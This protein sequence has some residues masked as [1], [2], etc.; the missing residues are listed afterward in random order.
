VAF[1]NLVAEN[2]AAA[3]P[4]GEEAA[5][6]R[7]LGA[8]EKLG[9]P[10]AVYSVVDVGTQ[11]RPERVDTTVVLEAKPPGISEAR[12]RLTAVF[13]G[14]KLAYF[15]P[16]IHV[17][18]SFLRE[19]RRRTA[20]D[21]L[22]LGARVVASGALVGIAIIL[23]LR[24]VRRPG[25]RW[26][27]I[28]TPLVAAG[29]LAAASLANTA[30]AA[31]R[32]YE[33]EKPF[34]L[35][36][37]GLGISLTVG[38]AVILLGALVGFVL[39]SAARPGWPAALRRRGSLGDAFGRAAI[40][41]AGLVGLVHWSHI[42]SSRLPS[43]YEPDPSLPDS[44]QFP[45]PELDVLW[46][47]ARGMFILALVA[48]V[49]ALALRTEFF[50][51][52]LGR[53]L[54]ALAILVAIAPSS[55][56]SPGLALAE[57]VPSVLVIAWLAASAAFLLRGHAAA[58]VLFGIFAFGGREVLALISQPAPPDRAAGW[59]GAALL[60]IA[61]AAVLAGRRT[62]E[63]APPAPPLPPPGPPAP[64]L[65]PETPTGPTTPWSG[66]A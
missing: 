14:P 40:A 23:F 45:L 41:A 21:W 46:T 38:L 10:A 37:L 4:P 56:R 58:W 51:A 43:L 7:A 63:P 26:R 39:L 3:P 34:A 62:P 61:A 18:E 49:A 42:L 17:P 32:Q 15:I 54:G 1:L 6:R 28:R 22:L 2:A 35:F 12:P 31:F 16:T 65:E 5:R 33:T 25:F 36:R 47:A 30:P 50:R 20:A 27:E 59:L 57:Y 29:V 8:A 13:H 52:P 11:A 9:Y 19:E 66:S 48:G 44:L 53:A 24:S 64:A 60:A 55:L